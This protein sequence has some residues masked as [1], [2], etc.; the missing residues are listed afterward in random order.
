MNRQIRILDNLPL[1]SSQ[2]IYLSNNKHA[3]HISFA[4]SYRFLTRICPSD[5]WDEVK[6]GFVKG[7][8]QGQMK[9]FW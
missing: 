9:G 3:K 8:S 1:S 5:R 2:L 4:V 7:S 6:Q